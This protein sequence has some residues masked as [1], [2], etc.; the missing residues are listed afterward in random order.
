M[1]FLGVGSMVLA[2]GAIFF[3]RTRRFLRTAVDTTGVI[4]GVGE[5]RDQDHG[6]TATISSRPSRRI[7]SRASSGA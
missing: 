5:R 6:T 7:P 1:T 2:L 3:A 4:I